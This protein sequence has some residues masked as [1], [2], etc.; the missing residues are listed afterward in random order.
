MQRLLGFLLLWAAALGCCRAQTAPT[1]AD[2][3]YTYTERMPIFPGGDSTDTRASF[4]RFKRFLEDSLRLPPLALRDH[5]QGQVFLSFTVAFDG[6]TTGLKVAKGLRPDVDSAVLRHARR[7]QRVRWQPG[8]Q[9]GKPVPVAFTVPVSFNL[10]AGWG[11]ATDSLDLPRFNN[12]RL[13]SAGWNLHHPRLPA[14]KGVIYGTCLQR[15][16][17]ASGGLGQYVRLVNLTTNEVFRLNV[18]PIMRSRRE[19]VFSYALPAGRYALSQYEYSTSSF[20][21][22]VERLRKPGRAGSPAVAASRYVFVVAAGQLHYVGTWNLANENEP[23]FMDEKAELDAALQPDFP[24][25][26]FGA[27]RVALPR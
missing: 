22:H 17:L 19:N 10:P 11:A 16:G 9:Q 13:P 20:N 24:E 18:K 26:D 7:L 3:P 23:I 6:R 21:I 4:G 25:A 2:K 8:T 1:V 5:V 14:G 15:L 12:L 27:A